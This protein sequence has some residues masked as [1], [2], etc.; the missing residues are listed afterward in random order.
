[1]RHVH[2][3][4]GLAVRD[5]PRGE[6]SVLLVASRYPNHPQPLW[7]LPGGRQQP[8]ELLSE[9]VEREVFEET[10]LRVHAGALAYLSESYDGPG[11]HFV[12]ATFQLEGYGAA[13]SAQAHA[14]PAAM[15]TS[16][17]WRGWHSRKSRHGLRLRS[18]ANL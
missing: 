3:A 4:S 15:T 1:M 10:Q 13:A 5:G 7:N 9:T 8:G 11:V 14:G 6:R 16:P 12:N 2:L 17:R 18:C